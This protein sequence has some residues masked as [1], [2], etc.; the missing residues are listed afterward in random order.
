MLVPRV[1]WGCGRQRESRG[2]R[3]Q[4]AF[5]RQD[6]QPQVFVGEEPSVEMGEVLLCVF[7]QINSQSSREME[8]IPSRGASSLLSG[9]TRV[10]IYPKQRSGRAPLR[11][12]CWGTQPCT[13]EGHRIWHQGP[14]CRAG[15]LLCLLPL[16]QHLDFTPIELPRK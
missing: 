8:I 11:Q 5:G 9:S 4:E 14:W 10:E 7:F 12:P 6:G 1:F 16:V 15:P 2:P 13:Q 3:P